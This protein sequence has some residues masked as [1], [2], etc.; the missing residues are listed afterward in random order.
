VVEYSGQPSFVT[1]GHGAEIY[2]VDTG[3]DYQGCHTAH[4]TLSGNDRQGQREGD[5]CLTSQP[6]N[7]PVEVIMHGQGWLWVHPTRCAARILDARC[8]CV[9]VFVCAWAMPRSEVLN[10]VDLA[11]SRLAEPDHTFSF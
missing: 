7:K 8:M 2:D 9:C 6:Y 3:F 1:A 5:G 4:T 11:S 10:C